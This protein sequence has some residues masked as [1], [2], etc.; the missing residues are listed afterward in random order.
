[1]KITGRIIDRKLRRTLK[2]YG[3]GR[4]NSE[5]FRKSFTKAPALVFYPPGGYV[6]LNEIFTR[7]VLATSSP[8]DRFFGVLSTPESV[9]SYPVDYVILLVR[10]SKPFA[11]RPPLPLLEAG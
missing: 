4:F 6:V 7:D 3:V 9:T 11:L 8:F 1:V 5:K 2:Y 10:H